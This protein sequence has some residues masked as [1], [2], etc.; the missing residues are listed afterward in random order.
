MN[1]TVSKVFR[2]DVRLEMRMCQSHKCR[3]APLDSENDRSNDRSLAF[4]CFT[5]P[6]PEM[7]KPRADD[8]EVRLCI[9]GGKVALWLPAAADKDFLRMI[10]FPGRR[11]CV[12]QE[13][14]RRWY[15]VQL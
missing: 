5:D 15:V 13:V 4:N 6:R 7:T 11:D 9:R 8:V 12:R 10:V 1:C 14:D 2:D 3:L